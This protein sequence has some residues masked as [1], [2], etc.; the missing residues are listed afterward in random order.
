MCST[1]AAAGTGGGDLGRGGVWGLSAA[2]E[3]DSANEWGVFGDSQEAAPQT[4]APRSSK[5]D[6]W[7][8]VKSFPA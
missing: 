5:C 8:A 2:L 6:V 4:R 3:F 1:G 7:N